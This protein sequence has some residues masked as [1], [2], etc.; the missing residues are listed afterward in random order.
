M[1]CCGS[2]APPAPAEPPQKDQARRK[3]QDYLDFSAFSR[4]G[5]IDQLEFEGFPT[6]AA[7]VAVDSLPIDWYEQAAKKA[8][9]Y[10]EFSAFSHSGLVDQLEFEGFSPDEAEHGATVALG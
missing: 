1:S 7:T 5:L 9:D 6:D 4:S 8:K 2:T 10:I 3:A